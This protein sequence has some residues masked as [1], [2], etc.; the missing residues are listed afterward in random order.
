MGVLPEARV[1]SGRIVWVLQGGGQ[2]TENG[3]ELNRAKNRSTEDS[4]EGIWMAVSEWQETEYTLWAFLISSGKDYNQEF[5]PQQIQSRRARLL[6][7]LGFYWDLWLTDSHSNTSGYI[8]TYFNLPLLTGLPYLS[9][10]LVTSGYTM[11]KRANLT[12][13]SSLII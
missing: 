13:C 11:E 12:Q 5:P 4:W 8:D 7:C 1:C 3:W 10:L 6:L 9:F 2:T